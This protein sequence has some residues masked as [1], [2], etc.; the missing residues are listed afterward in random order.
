MASAYSAAVEDL[1]TC[2][3]CLRRYRNPKLLHCGHTFCCHCIFRPYMDS[4]NT[5]KIMCPF[6]RQW[7]PLSEMGTSG[8]Q[9][10]FRIFQIRDAFEALSAKIPSS[11]KDSKGQQT[12][13]MEMPRKRK[14]TEMESPDA[15]I[16]CNS[17]ISNVTDTDHDE[18]GMSLQAD[19]EDGEDIFVGLRQVSCAETG[20]KETTG[21]RVSVTSGWDAACLPVELVAISDTTGIV[22][23]RPLADLNNVLADTQG[24][25]PHSRQVTGARCTEVAAR[26]S[27]AV[28]SSRPTTHSRA[29]V[30][31]LDSMFD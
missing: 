23:I 22:S 13:M 21:D 10:D 17:I 4:Q 29:A 8:L 12:D 18:G 1:L 6:C 7:T 5:S 25:R 26:Q 24:H 15:S 3:I 16:N 2:A 27:W 30:G 14:C 11:E 9:D 28:Y 31:A 19:E 20:N